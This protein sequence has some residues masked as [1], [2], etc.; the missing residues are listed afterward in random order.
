MSRSKL[1]PLLPVLAILFAGLADAQIFSFQSGSNIAVA[2]LSTAKILPRKLAP[3]ADP[4][5]SPDGKW[6]AFTHY[7][8]DGNRRIAIADITTAKWNLVKGIPG[9][10][11]YLPI[12]SPDGKYLYF[13]H[14]L[15]S[16]WVVARVDPA[17]GNFQILKNLPRQHGSYAWFPNG[18]ELLCH[19]IESFFVIKFEGD[20]KAVLR[21]IPKAANCTGLYTPSRI[22][23]AP[24]EK[25]ALFEM[26]VEEETSPD[27]QGSAVFLLNLASGKITR[28]SP[29]G[30]NGTSPSWLPGGKEFLFAGSDPKTSRSTI[31][32]AAVNAGSP[33]GVV[34]KNA[35]APTVARPR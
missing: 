30:Y 10:N 13:N 15:E 23:V 11:S 26:L 9:N 18:K 17:G 14:F 6:V 19:N 3:G 21:D 7:D 4:S 16:D 1:I 20:G 32:R 34:L 25:S 22:D 24:D 27:H 31:Y 8:S 33:P 12:W 2:D 28:L 35:S 29:K 5:I